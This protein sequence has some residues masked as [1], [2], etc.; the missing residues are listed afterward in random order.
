MSDYLII[1]GN[2]IEVIELKIRDRSVDC[3]FTSPNPPSND[4]EVVSLVQFFAKCKRIVSD[5]G[6]LWVNMG[7]HYHDNLGILPMNEYFVLAMR[8]EG[9][10]L[11]DDI[12]WHKFPPDKTKPED[13]FRFRRDVEHI[14]GFAHDENHYF[15]DRIGLH[16]TSVIQCPTEIIK[17]GEFKSGFPEKVAEICVKP[18][19]R[20]NDIV[21]DPFVGSGTTGVVALKMNRN[22]IG[23]DSAPQDYIDKINN[24]LSRFGSKDLM[25][26][27]EGAINVLQK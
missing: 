5:M 23:I 14:Y 17:K 6:R 24:R 10:V 3:I 19:T 1:Q 20:P 18:T 11:R 13:P 7:N 2:A 4:P 25:T 16:N 22:F 12:I 15:N 21:L 9:W 27:I 8:Q 26:K